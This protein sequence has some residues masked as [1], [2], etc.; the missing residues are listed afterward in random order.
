MGKERTFAAP[1][2]KCGKTVDCHVI[3]VLEPGDEALQTLFKSGL[4]VQTCPACKAKFTVDGPL[5]YKESE[6]PYLVFLEKF[7][8]DGDIE[9]LEQQIDELVTNVSNDGNSEK[10]EVRVVFSMPDFLEKVALRKAGFDDRLVEY[11][12]LQL[13]RTMDEVQLSRSQHRLMYD[14]E[15][16]NDDM[17]YFLVYDRNTSQVVNL[18]QVPMNEYHS[19]ELALQASE[20][21]SAELLTAFPGSYVSAERLL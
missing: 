19:L 16:S 4:N 12:K 3:E 17:L 15:H 14:F 2:P 11:A 21:A 9:S 10:P 6:P 1:C 18:L 20:E 5:V 8:E 7:P 13:F